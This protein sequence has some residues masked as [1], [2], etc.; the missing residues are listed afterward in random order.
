MLVPA[1]GPKA[2]QRLPEGWRAVEPS[3][4]AL[5]PMTPTLGAEVTG[6]DLRTPLGT[7]TLRELWWALLEWKLLVF[8]D[9]PLEPVDHVGVALRFG[10]LFDD[11]TDAPRKG[12][13]LDN[14]IRFVREP[15]AAGLDNVW[16]AD[17]SFRLSP[18]V[19][20]SLHAIEVPSVGG[21]TL[22]VDMAVAYDNLADDVRARVDELSAI[23]DWSA[24]FYAQAGTYGDRYEAIKASL[25]PVQH[26]V[27]RPHPVTGRTTLYTN[28]AFTAGLVGGDEELFDL[29]RAQAMV[30]EYQARLRWRPNTFILFDNQALQHYATNNYLPH[31]RV[32]GRATIESWS[33]EV[34]ALPLPRDAAARTSA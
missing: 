28:M 17:G 6:L 29:L 26:R 19:A 5:D 8:R 3:T 7:E 18:P 21:D 11:S 22:F 10:S 15:G 23:N 13:P 14:Y 31:R 33:D 27:A 20:L 9:Q 1:P 2:M 16:H 24:G 32:I 30:P 25:P 34:L 4:F 12:D